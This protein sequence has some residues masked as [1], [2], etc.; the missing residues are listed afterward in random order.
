MIQ[1]IFFSLLLIVGVM[2]SGCNTFTDGNARNDIAAELTIKY[3]TMKV[4]ER[5]GD[6]AA[7]AARIADIA[8]QAKTLVDGGAVA[9]VPELEIIVRQKIPWSELDAADTLLA[10]AL[11][12]TLRTELMSRVD[13]GTLDDKT[14]LAV[15][16]VLDSVVEA[17]RLFSG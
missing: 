2:L 16:K 7:K 15:T 1:R 9:F 4:I 3:A 11:L 8:A 17:T 5:S 13:G 10:D 12:T 6:P 14:R